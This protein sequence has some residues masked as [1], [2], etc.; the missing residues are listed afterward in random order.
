MQTRT[1]FETGGEYVPEEQA[2]TVKEITMAQQQHGVRLQAEKEKE[3]KQASRET[4]R[5]IK[6]A[7]F[8]ADNTTLT[9][10]DDAVTAGGSKPGRGSGKGAGKKQ[11]AKVSVNG[12]KGAGTSNP[13][14]DKKQAKA[15]LES[16]WFERCWWFQN[17]FR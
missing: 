1:R 4:E 2:M 12:P 5:H 8:R 3:K 17:R 14:A 15:R 7:V 6:A 16:Q 11:P 13:A 9:A 10:H